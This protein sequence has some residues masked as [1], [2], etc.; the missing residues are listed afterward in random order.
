VS[1]SVLVA[2][3]SVVMTTTLAHAGPAGTTAFGGRGATVDYRPPVAG[4]VVDPFRPPSHPYGPGNRGLDYAVAPGSPVTAAADGEVV[5]AGAVGTSLHVTVRHDDDLRTSYSF[6]ATVAVRAGERIRQGQPLGSA[7]GRVH[8]GVRDRGGAYLDPAS[9]F[10]GDQPYVRLVPGRD[11]GRSGLSTEVGMLRRLIAQRPDLYRAATQHLL[12]RMRVMAHYATELR[13]DMRAAHLTGA[14]VDWMKQSA[15]CTPTG[16]VP[17]PFVERRIAVLVGGLGSTSESAA[18]DDV[19]VAQLGYR[20]GDVVRF[21]YEGGRVPDPSD[22]P[23][24]RAITAAPYGAV[25]THRELAVSAERLGE[26]LVAVAAAEPGIPI[27]VIAH[28]QGG[29]VATLALSAWSEAGADPPV[30]TLVTLGSPHGGADLATA[31]VAL[32]LTPLGRVVEPLAGSSGA[33][34]SGPAVRDLSEVSS[35]TAR[36]PAQQVPPSVGFV[37]IAARGDVVVPAARSRVAGRPSAVVSLTHPDAHGRLPGAPETTRE[38][39]LAL[40]GRPP[41]CRTL[42]QAMSDAAAGEAISFTTDAI[43]ASALFAGRAVR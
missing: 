7:F 20:A 34:P 28:S 25:A 43:G 12:E 9:L 30:A 2:V 8:F 35:T 37:S 5:F 3:V 11:E 31:A 4:E 42:G 17:P 16:E 15:R 29:V 23:R 6:L 19:A 38:I 24:L 26:L 22:G 39:A 36:Q 10:H 18:I 13:L 41:T 14:M 32:G 1:R 21:S 27:D 33:V 40:Q